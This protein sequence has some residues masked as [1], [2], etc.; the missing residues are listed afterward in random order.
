M[1]PANPSSDSAGRGAGG[2]CQ[3]HAGEVVCEGAALHHCGADGVTASQETCM[4]EALCQLGKTA[5][6]CA[7]CNP[8][9]FR[10]QGAELSM[11]SDAGQYIKS[12]DCA[13]AALCNADAGRCTDMVCVPNAV[14][15]SSDGSTLKTCNADGS[16][17]AENTSCGAAGCNPTLKVCN[18]CMPG[19]RTCSGNSVMV[20]SSDGQRTDT[21]QCV[22][23]GGECAVAACQNGSCVE[24]KKPSGASCSGGNKCDSNGRCVACLSAQE[25]PDPGPCSDRKCS[26]GVCSPTKKVPGASCGLNMQCNSNG[27]CEQKPCGNGT[28]DSGEQ[29]DPKEDAYVNSGGACGDDC[30]LSRS[31]YRTCGAQGSEC[32]R[33]SMSDGW[34]C[35]GVGICTKDCTNGNA[36]QCNATGQ[37]TRCVASPVPDQRYNAC[38]AECP[39]CPGGSRCVTFASTPGNSIRF[40]GSHDLYV[41][42]G[43]VQ[44][45]AC[46][47]STP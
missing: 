29:C 14:S 30:R 21:M 31:V 9:T 32:W 41:C 35:S 2:V 28:R 8:G 33:G 23:A 17:F 3:G 37:T 45:T 7:L 25:C 1:A 20:C 43:V 42:N 27:S 18:K 26:A 36:S 34:L 44:E 12:Q 4:T 15:C 10:C 19:M 22:A 47:P 46:P 16:A 5:G 38:V 40:C 11:C 6:A 39:S 24:T 13:T